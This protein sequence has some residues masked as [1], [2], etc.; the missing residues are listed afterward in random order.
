MNQSQNFHRICIFTIVGACVCCWTSFV[1]GQML[2]PA[3]PSTQ[4]A[5]AP[6]VGTRN[7]TTQAAGTQTSGTD[8]RLTSAYNAATAS[9]AA[10]RQNDF[11]TLVNLM[12][13]KAIEDG[14]GREQMIA[15]A[16]LAKDTL[17]LQTEGFD[18]QV[19]FPTR[20]I[21]VGE[22]RFTIV[23]QT[24]TIRLKSDQAL[25]RNSYLLGVSHDNGRSWR[26]VDGASGAQKIR[27]LFPD[28]PANSLPDDIQR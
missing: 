4:A 25:D 17:E 21:E 8:A 7:Q 2:Q 11:E 26:F 24:V 22:T 5:G 28:I 6:N 19:H 20:I 3:V 14:G 1:S 27:E 23:P 10:F 13:E 12:H 18:S 9:L 16:Q 15:T